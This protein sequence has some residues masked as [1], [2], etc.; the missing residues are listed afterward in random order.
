[1]ASSYFEVKFLDYVPYFEAQPCRAGI[2]RLC[3]TLSGTR[4]HTEL[5]LLKRIPGGKKSQLLHAFLAK[6][7]IM[8]EV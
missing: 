2:S 5:I 1:M 6:M 7:R 8:Q 3:S 4:A